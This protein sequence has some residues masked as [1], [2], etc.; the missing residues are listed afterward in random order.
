MKLNIFKKK[1]KAAEEQQ[2]LTEEQETEAEALVGRELDE[3][4]AAEEIAE[5]AEEEL[6]AV[7]KAEEAAEDAAEAARAALAESGVKVDESSFPTFLQT[8]DLPDP[9]I[10]VRTGGEHRISNFLLYQ[11]AYSELYFSDTLWPDFTA[12]ELDD[13]LKAY[14]KTDRRF[15]GVD[16]KR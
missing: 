15:G 10:I 5:T 2:E 3:A 6:A 16:E 8:A 11:M 13:I 9:D 12:K 14:S 7:Q 1:A 4:S